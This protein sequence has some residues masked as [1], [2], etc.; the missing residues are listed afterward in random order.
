MR[1]D[2]SDRHGR[3]A[4]SPRGN[5]NAVS[6]P[7]S[8]R[9]NGCARSMRPASSTI[10]SPAKAVSSRSPSNIGSAR[11]STSCSTSGSI[12][13]NASASAAPKKSGIPGVRHYAPASSKTISRSRGCCSTAEPTP[14]GRTVITARLYI[15]LT[16]TRTLR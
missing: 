10:R 2:R 7:G 1:G 6:R 5:A 9:S 11:L 3:S 14:T 8:A 12:P 15:R 16:A 13:M 4:A